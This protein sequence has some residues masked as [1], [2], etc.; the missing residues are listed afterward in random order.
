MGVSTD[1]ILVYGFDLGE[2]E[3]IE[4]ERI[5]DVIEKADNLEL[6]DNRAAIVGHCSH[7][8]RMIIVAVPNTK[9]VAK[10]GYPTTIDP[11]SMAVPQE[12][13]AELRAFC[14]AHGIPWQEPRWILCSM[15]H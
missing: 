6:E 1:A 7:D 10:R 15:W 12:R 8:Y 4:D 5:R 14:E 13:V 11:A 2:E 9:R 3:D